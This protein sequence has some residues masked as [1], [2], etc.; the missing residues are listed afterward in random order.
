MA[1]NVGER[2]KQLKHEKGYSYTEIADKTGLTTSYISNIHQG[3]TV[4]INNLE[5]ICSAIGI[6]LSQFFQADVKPVDLSVLEAIS[7]LSDE[8]KKQLALFINGLSDKP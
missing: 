8:K 1:F 4:G 3:K 5:K 2:L 6:T 7:G